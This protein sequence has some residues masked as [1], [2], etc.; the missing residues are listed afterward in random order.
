[1]IL[2]VWCHAKSKQPF[3]KWQ[4]RGGGEGRGIFHVYIKYKFSIIQC[5]FIG[6]K[7]AT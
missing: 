5:V 4:F 6:E 7:D 3:T 2:Q 1:M